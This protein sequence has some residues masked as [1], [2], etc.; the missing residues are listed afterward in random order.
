[1]ACFP[2]IA[3]ARSLVVF[4]GLAVTVAGALFLG[5]SSASAGNGSNCPATAL[6]L[7]PGT[8]LDGTPAVLYSGTNNVWL[9]INW[10]GGIDSA[11]SAFNNRQNKTYIG[12]C[13]PTSCSDP[14]QPNG[15]D[16]MGPGGER[17]N[18]SNWAYA[19]GWLEWD[20]IGYVDFIGV[21]T[22]C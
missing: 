19:D 8:N 3:K 21:G 1:M 14:P 2:R 10:S 6:C 4:F 16:C 12:E 5:V 20:N 18:L 17:L 11:K 7:Y 9:A 13:D 15:K 22:T